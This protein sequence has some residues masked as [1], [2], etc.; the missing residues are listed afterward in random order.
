MRYSKEPTPRSLLS[1]LLEGIA[2]VL[3]VA[4][5][6]DLFSAIIFKHWLVI[7]ISVT[8][9]A[10]LIIYYRLRKPPNDQY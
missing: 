8:V 4:Y 10:I 6:L 5:L 3:I 2:L 1:Y 7:L 9:I